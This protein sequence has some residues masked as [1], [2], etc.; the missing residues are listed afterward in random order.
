MLWSRWT[1]KMIAYTFKTWTKTQ[2]SVMQQVVMYEAMQELDP[3]MGAKMFRVGGWGPLL[4]LSWRPEGLPNG[5]PS[6][7]LRCSLSLLLLYDI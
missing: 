7:E 2:R 4:K 6:S 3:M 1:S 5:P